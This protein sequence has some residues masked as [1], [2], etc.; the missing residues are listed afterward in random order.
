MKPCQMCDKDFTPQSRT[1]AFCSKTCASTFQHILNP[2]PR[3]APTRWAAKTPEQRV[4]YGSEYRRKRAR[5]VAEAIG[6]P[7]PGCGVVLTA[8]NTTADHIAPRA[9]GGSSTLANLRALCGACNHRRGASLGGRV[10]AARKR[11]ARLT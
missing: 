6:S 4:A 8:A 1:Q 3:K 11:A 7:C 5:V 2:R 10:T 9:Q